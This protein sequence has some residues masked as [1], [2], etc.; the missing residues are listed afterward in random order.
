MVSD[1]VMKYYS[2]MVTELGKTVSNNGDLSNDE[3]RQLMEKTGLTLNQLIFRLASSKADLFIKLQ[4]TE[5]ENQRLKETCRRQSRALEKYAEESKLSK[6][7]AE[8]R[9]GK[10]LAE[11]L[12][13]DEY[14]ILIRQGYTNSMI[15]EKFGVSRSTIWRKQKELQQRVVNRV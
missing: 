4:Q 12:S 14:E 2:D 5:A 1:I 13:T 9:N 3:I 6:S 8:V 10:R 15:M 11:K 7:A